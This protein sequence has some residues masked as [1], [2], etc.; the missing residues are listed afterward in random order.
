[1]SSKQN[2]GITTNHL[3]ISRNQRLGVEKIQVW[4]EM[5]YISKAPENGYLSEWYQPA[6][7]NIKCCL[8]LILLIFMINFGA[9]PIALRC[10]T[11]YVGRIIQDQKLTCSFCHLQLAWYEPP[12]IWSVFILIKRRKRVNKYNIF[13]WICYFANNKSSNSVAHCFEWPR[14]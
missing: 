5:H 2:S 1:M 7:T 3:L 8:W 11:T 10:N 6:N 12:N 14:R 13:R 9:W 4:A